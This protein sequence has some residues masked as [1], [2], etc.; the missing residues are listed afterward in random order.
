M[1]GQDGRN[2][3]WRRSKARPRRTVKRQAVEDDKF[4]IPPDVVRRAADATRR[5][6]KVGITPDEMIGMMTAADRALNGNSNDV[7]RDVLYKVRQ[8]L[9]ELYEDASRWV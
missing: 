4:V 5:G 8:R 7:E 9:S 3:A 2:L 1:D 6:A